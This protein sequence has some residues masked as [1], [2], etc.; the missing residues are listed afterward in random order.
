MALSQHAAIPRWLAVPTAPLHPS[1]QEERTQARQQIRTALAA[2][3]AQALG[4]QL[5]ALHI[6]HT[7]GQ[8]PRLLREGHVLPWGLSISHAPGL[9]LAAWHPQGAV[10][11]DVQAVPQAV[12]PGELLH[13]AAI[14]LGPET[15]AAL[16]KQAQEAHFLIAFAQHWAAHEA[17]LKCLG[18]GLVEYHPALAA[19]LAGVQVAPLPLPAWAGAG[20]VAALALR[21]LCSGP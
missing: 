14:F 2:Q 18:L 16:A 12:A 17:A 9:S 21:R 10:G 7:P 5:Q 4:C 15:A 3:I 11:I 13:T 1:A 19:Q 8:P 6:T 20:R